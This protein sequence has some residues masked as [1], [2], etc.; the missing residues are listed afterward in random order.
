[1]EEV[2][3]NFE[4]ADNVEND[5]VEDKKVIIEEEE[6]E[7]ED[8]EL[9]AFLEGE[10]KKKDEIHFPQLKGVVDLKELNKFPNVKTLFFVN[11]HIRRIKN[12]PS[13]II[14]INAPNNEIQAIDELPESLEVL[15]VAH[16]AIKTIDLGNVLNLTELNVSYN[17]LAK[18]E[19]LPSSL[20][21]LKCEF[22]NISELDLKGLVIKQLYCN[23]NPKLRLLNIPSTIEDGNYSNN[24]INQ[25]SDRDF[26]H[27]Y[28]VM[29][30]DYRKKL[31]EYFKL[32]SHYENEVKK[33]YR[34][35]NSKILEANRDKNPKRLFQ[36]LRNFKNP[37]S[38]PPCKG[39]GKDGGMSFTITSD[40]YGAQCA[41]NPK[42]D[43]KLAIN[44]ATFGNRE[45]LIYEYMTDMEELKDLFIKSKM[46][47]LFR[48]FSDDS[49]KDSFQ[50][51]MKSYQFCGEQLKKHLDTHNHI[52]YNEEKK[53]LI[54]DKEKEINTFLEEVKS[55]LA[56][57][58]GEDRQTIIDD[59]VR[60]QD[61]EIRPLVEYIRRLRYES[62][63]M[64]DTNDRT[65]YKLCTEEVTVDK[66]DSLLSGTMTVSNSEKDIDWGEDDS[67]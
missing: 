26:P 15:N 34:K 16:N 14:R 55:K 47:S 36:K 62:F 50:K 12:I 28:V 33:A 30:T 63:K 43:W 41:N 42:C 64:I 67:F 27:D 39:C 52:Y 22:N 56:D 31:D 11:G 18:L 53:K 65:E 8:E 40:V 35:A 49:I 7:E 60:I 19:R 66:L 59:V 37:K 6:E 24:L 25:N 45:K 61:T 54:Q 57:T 38:M 5:K 9:M 46:D 44:R 51:R 10:N 23:N 20:E 1:M 48:Y 4:N 32:K 17:K 21:V 29:Q 3:I 58:S 2:E 13:T